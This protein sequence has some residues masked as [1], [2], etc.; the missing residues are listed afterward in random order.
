MRKLAP[1]LMLAAFFALL[2]P[3]LLQS[4]AQG[5]VY[6]EW[7]TM[8]SDPLGL[9]V[10][11]LAL[12]RTGAVQ[13]ERNYEP[14]RQARPRRA[15]YVMMGASPTLLQDTKD[16]DKLLSAGG[17]V[18]V[19]LRPANAKTV[20]R[21]EKLGFLQVTRTEVALKSG[22][23]KCLLG[24]PDYCKLAAKGRLW[25][26]ADGSP[27]RNGELHEERQ[28]DLL[29]RL[30]GNGL[31]VVF[32]ESHLGVVESGGVGVLLKRYR[33]FPAVGMLFFAALL[34]VW[35]NSVSL[36]PEREPVTPA[37]T[38]QPAASLRTLLAQRVPKNKLLVTLVDEWKRA[39]PLLPS[40]H[41]GRA[42]HIE[43][44]LERALAT[45]DLRQG[46]AELQS[47][48]RLRKGST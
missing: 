48:I 19:A 21:T 30:F 15:Q 40:W 28:T 41:S 17:L 47:A 29:A 44:A 22:D 43:A 24:S 33:L 31:P 38:P 26:L 16:L 23:W 35:R 1:I 7:S 42:G 13:V 6:P 18:L 32:D 37:M 11:Y 36:L 27:L 9:K 34:F 10:L 2:L 45:K 20:L 46:Y 8:R 14:W 4:I 3:R 25:L 12:E 5:D 39:L